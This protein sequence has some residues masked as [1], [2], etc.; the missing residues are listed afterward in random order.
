MNAKRKR[1]A[2]ILTTSLALAAAFLLCFLWFHSAQSGRDDL[3]SSMPGSAETVL[4]VDLHDMRQA[5]FFADLMAWA[6]KPAVD[7][8]YDQ[9]RRDTG[10][11]YEKDLDRIAM[12]FEKHGTQ[13]I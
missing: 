9:F 5:P 11:D 7:V 10:F 3:M 13:Q 4:F 1:I 8:D 6:P 2:I 12:A